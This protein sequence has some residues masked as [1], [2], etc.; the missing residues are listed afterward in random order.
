MRRRKRV[1]DAPAIVW[2]RQD[3]RLADNPALHAAI[4]SKCALILLYILDDETPGRWRWGGA[5]RWWLHNSLD[6]LAKDIAKRGGVLVLRRGQ[7][8]TELPRLVAETGAGAVYW[9]RC[10]EPYATQRDSALK[11]KLTRA[12]VEAQSFNGAL[13]FEPWTIKTKTGEPYKVFTPFWRAC[14]QMGVGRPL[15]PAPKKLNGFDGELQSD[16]LNDWRLLPTKPN[17]ASNFATAWAPGE[18]GAR[19]ALEAFVAHRLRTYPE[20]RDQ[21]GV[22][23]TSRLSPHLHFGEISPAQVAAAVEAAA[24]TQPGLRRGAEKFLTEIG[25]REFSTHLLFHWPALPER[26]WKDQFDAFA[27]RDD[28]AALEAWRRGRTGYPV[29]D[30]AMR[31][32]WATGY[33]HNRARMIAASFLIKHLL[34]DWRHGED[35]FWDTLVDADLANNAASWQWV[36]GSGADASPY[37]RIFNPVTQGER[38]DADGAYVR[39]WVPEL[40][41]LPNALLHKPWEADAVTRAAAGVKLGESYPQPLVDHAV[42]RARALEAYA[43]ISSKN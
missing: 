7:A 32:L 8:E 34:I 12:G 28:V 43:A 13:L 18:T 20:A 29:V 36:A 31:E 24:E 38:Y 14:V 35:W 2:L 17:W 21:L 5:S 6:A 42:A 40:A 22:N 37:F 19:G 39:R 4:Q 10:Y 9:N 23:G 25:W 26:N 33:M 41:G 11:E 30:A 27:W 16:R 3:L 1:A 15:L